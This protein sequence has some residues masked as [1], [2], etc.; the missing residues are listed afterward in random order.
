MSLRRYGFAHAISGF[1]EFPTD[2][3]R[4]LVPRP[5]EP[6]ELHHG[7]SVLSVTVFDFVESC[8]G[9][10]RELVLAVAVMPL[11]RSG[12]RLPKS[13]L[14]PYLVATSTAEAREHA[15]CTWHL[16]HWMEDAEFDIDHEDGR[17]EARVSVGGAPVADLSVAQHSW[18]PVSHLYQSFMRDGEECFVAD[19]LMEGKQSEHEDE[20][21]R[22]RLHEH[23][24]NGG[25]ALSEVSDVPFREVWMRDGLQT[26]ENLV[27]L[28]AS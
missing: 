23:P 11:V 10:Y 28:P 1:F 8:V 26:F 20:A 4:R 12:E 2:N 17:I 3:A 24:F 27:S 13:A 9:P 22:V 15:I 16:P 5:L 6:V 25:L 19:I 18:Q 7:S 21:G 14:Y